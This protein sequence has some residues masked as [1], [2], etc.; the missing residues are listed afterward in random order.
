MRRERGGRKQSGVKREKGGR[1]QSWVRRERGLR[2][3]RGVWLGTRA[4]QATV[5]VVMSH[6][7]YICKMCYF[8]I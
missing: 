4:W 7:V 5:I 1:R 8:T 6:N 3:E 2:R